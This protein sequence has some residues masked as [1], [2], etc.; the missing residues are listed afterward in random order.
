MSTTTSLYLLLKL[1]DLRHLIDTI[2]AIALVL[3]IPIV[4]VGFFATIL[5]ED[6]SKPPWSNFF[7]KYLI[8]C[9]L[10]LTTTI[11]SLVIGTILPSTKQ[12]AAIYIG[13]MVVESESASILS[14]LPA[15]YAT[16]LSSHADAYIEGIIGEGDEEDEKD[17][18]D[19]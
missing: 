9:L 17:E 3:L 15:K 6:L 13:S 7:K 4:I 12:M 18:K 5:D 14:K 8:T 10:L 16:I 19:E 11:T 1:D 2:G